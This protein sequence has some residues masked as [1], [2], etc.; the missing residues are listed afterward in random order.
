MGY[1][2]G[3][4]SRSV[5]LVSVI[6]ATLDSVLTSRCSAIQL[7]KISDR[8]PSIRSNIIRGRMTSRV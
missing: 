5:S 3:G 6:V 2:K 1:K 8:G 7:Y 4:I